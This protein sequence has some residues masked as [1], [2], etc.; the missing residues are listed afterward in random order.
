MLKRERCFSKP[1]REGEIS[2][3]ESRIE[4]QGNSNLQLLLESRD[5]YNLTGIVVCG[6]SVVQALMRMCGFSSLPA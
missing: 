6:V 4:M 3:N 2:T 5:S 1:Y